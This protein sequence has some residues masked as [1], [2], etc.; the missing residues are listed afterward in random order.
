M[1][2]HDP[3]Q[4]VRHAS[5]ADQEIKQQHDGQKRTHDEC[6]TVL[7]HEAE[8]IRLTEPVAQPVDRSLG[9]IAR[10]QCGSEQMN[11]VIADRLA[12][13]VL[14]HALQVR[15]DRPTLVEEA[16]PG[17]GQ[18]R[19]DDAEQDEKQDDRKQHARPPGSLCRPVQ[20]RR[21]NIGDDA[22]QHEGQQ[23]QLDEIKKDGE[24]DRA[25][26]DGAGFPRVERPRSAGSL[27]GTLLVASH[28]HSL[29]E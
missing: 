19:N 12:G 22:G 10:G 15:G 28:A 26:H 18:D 14:E 1:R 24:D 2:R 6:E 3:E 21:E 11:R 13:K 27:D 16:L 9:N 8:L 17:Q 4:P 20:A 29:H 5:A 7:G 25:D 23:N